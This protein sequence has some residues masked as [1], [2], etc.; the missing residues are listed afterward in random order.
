M[1]FGRD[2]WLFGS[3]QL[4]M[5][6]NKYL[7][8]FSA[9]WTAVYSYSFVEKCQNLSANSIFTNKLEQLPK[10]YK[11]MKPLYIF[12]R[13]SFLN[14]L[15]FSLHQMHHHL[16]QQLQLKK[17]NDLRLNGHILNFKSFDIFKMTL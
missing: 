9:F 10:I 5:V 3:L 1:T 14:A 15:Y 6:F 16:L 12:G 4:S 2:T 11:G 7:W 17:L 8:G 13:C